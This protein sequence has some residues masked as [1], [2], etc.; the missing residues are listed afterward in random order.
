[1]VI[2]N[3]NLC[4]D[5]LG[6]YKICPLKVMGLK[7]EKVK[8]ERPDNC[9][10]CGHCISVCPVKAIS[11]DFVSSIPGKNTECIKAAQYTEIKDLIIS[12][13]SIRSYD[14]REVEKEKVQK[15][16]NLAAYAPT[17]GNR[18]QVKYVVIGSKGTNN[19][20]K[21]A[22]DFFVKKYEDKIGDIVREADFSVL[23]GAPVLIGFYSDLKYVD[24]DCVIAAHNAVLAATSMG[25]GTCYNGILMRAYSE[26]KEIQEF[27]GLSENYRIHIF[28]VLGYP[29]SSVKYYHTIIRND[30]NILWID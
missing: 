9:I 14:K 29:D 21:L 27:F 25:L 2:I 15:I 23:L 12:R 11:G 19:L 10:S 7:E 5:C 18:Q 28:I 24:V 22:N 6:C 17:G 3:Y 26:S 4:I 8:I 13:R 1:M 16:L 20:E 30:P